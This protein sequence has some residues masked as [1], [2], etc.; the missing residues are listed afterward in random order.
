MRARSRR[1]TQALDAKVLRI[2][3]LVLGEL[4]PYFC[5]ANRGAENRAVERSGNCLCGIKEPLAS[6]LVGSLADT[7]SIVDVDGKTS[8]S[9][10]AEERKKGRRLAR[11]RN[12]EADTA[13]RG[14][15]GGLARRAA[16]T[17]GSKQARSE[18]CW[19]RTEPEIRDLQSL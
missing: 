17:R 4:G 12:P 5:N 9:G 3:V 16:D 18:K 14:A 10:A 19:T 6:L 11:V 8:E 15:D 13:Q 2:L 1:A 7:D